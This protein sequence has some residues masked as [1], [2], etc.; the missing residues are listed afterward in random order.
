MQPSVP[1]ARKRRIKAVGA[2]SAP[3]RG[4][5]Q[6]WYDP[7]SMISSPSLVLSRVMALGC[8]GAFALVSALSGGA[9]PVASPAYVGDGGAAEPRAFAQACSRAQAKYAARDFAGAAVAYQEAVALRPGDAL[10]RYLLGEAW[11]AA[12]NLAAAESEW[13]RA[14]AA[15]NADPA[16][17]ARVLFVL[18][19]LRERQKKWAEAKAGWSTYREW[20]VRFPSANAFP[21]SADARIAA[22]DK[23]LEQDK[24]YEDVRRRIAETADGGVYNDLSKGPDAAK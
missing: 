18:A 2:A 23:M 8:F 5:A 13:G 14:M 3:G 11:L 15:E 20:A 7:C 21:A 6:T 12:G 24:R 19:D 17:H 4:A 16:V 10:G 22:I 9:G 1:F